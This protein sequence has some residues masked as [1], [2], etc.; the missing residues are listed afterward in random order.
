[1]SKA[2]AASAAGLF[3]RIIVALVFLCGCLG[4]VGIHEEPATPASINEPAASTTTTGVQAP[5]DPSVYLS[6]W[7]EWLLKS[8]NISVEYFD[9]HVK[10]NS[11]GYESYVDTLFRVRYDIAVGWVVV[12]GE[13]KII[14][15]PK[16]SAN[17]L[18]KSEI[19]GISHYD[20]GLESR[21][22][23]SNGYGNSKKL[24]EING[25]AARDVVERTLMGCHP[26]MDV[27]DRNIQWDNRGG[28]KVIRQVRLDNATGV[29]KLAVVN[30]ET[31]ELE[32]CVE[33]TC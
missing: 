21:V 16:S 30:L 9:E 14:V 32:L 27:T 2:P 4:G 7:E 25:V 19:Y 11:T 22:Y 10:V 8:Q 28:L 26:G 23:V 3:P 5:P 24:R 1:L 20:D 6:M 13:D 29:C 17:F 31:G 15:K 12:H 33:K 18:S